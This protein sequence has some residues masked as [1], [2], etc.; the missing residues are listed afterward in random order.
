MNFDDK[1]HV[2]LKYQLLLFKKSL[3]K[4]YNSLATDETFH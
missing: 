1:K 3:S 4:S 2:R